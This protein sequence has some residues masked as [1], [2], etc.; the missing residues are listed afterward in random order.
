MLIDLWAWLRRGEEREGGMYGEI[1]T[2]KYI[3]IH[4]TNGQWEFAV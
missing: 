1:N 2:E 3:T 4:K